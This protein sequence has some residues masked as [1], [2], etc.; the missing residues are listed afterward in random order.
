[1]NSVPANLPY[2]LGD[3]GRIIQVFHNLIGNACKFTHS[4]QI[5]VEAGLTADN[6]LQVSVNDNGIGIPEDKF[7]KVFLAFEQ[8]SLARSSL[9]YICTIA[10]YVVL[11][12][13]RVLL[14]TYNLTISLQ[15]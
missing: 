12:C 7:D 5:W 10:V 8:V 3:A 6:M 2:V 1:M 15:I 9:C 4:G 13:R 11:Q 14:S